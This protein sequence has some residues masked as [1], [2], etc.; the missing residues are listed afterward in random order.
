MIQP[1][2][3]VHEPVAPAK[4][5]VDRISLTLPKSDAFISA[6]RLTVAGIG[7]RAGLSFETIEDL[8]IIVSEACTYCTR[9][10][11]SA[12]KLHVGL[13]IGRGRVVVSISDSGFV[14]APTSAPKRLP[15]EYEPDELF[16]IR[17]LADEFNHRLTPGRGL[18]LR[19]TKSV[20]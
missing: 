18:K 14:L 9:R 15:G 7:M 8:K 13:E 16:I 20:D 17:N 6:V 11:G 10:G 19:I 4:S 1:V 2:S 3:H 12:G 5:G